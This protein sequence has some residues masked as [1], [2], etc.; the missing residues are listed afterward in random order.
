[1]RILNDQ[2]DRAGVSPLTLIQ[3][4]IAAALLILAVYQWMR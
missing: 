4:V 2:P 1:M 3:I